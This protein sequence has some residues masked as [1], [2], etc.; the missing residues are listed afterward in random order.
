MARRSF[1]WCSLKDLYLACERVPEELRDPVTKFMAYAHL[2]VNEVSKKYL[3]NEKRY[4]YT[5]PKSFLAL[6]SLYE[7][8]LEKKHAELIKSMDRL[9]NG[10]TK[11]QST[12]SQVDDLKAKLAVQEV[13]LKQKNEKQNYL[14]N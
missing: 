2:S 7:E 14:L 9:E 8:M 11:L 12:S 4:N 13:E 10:L 3:L 6:I 1:N 5:T